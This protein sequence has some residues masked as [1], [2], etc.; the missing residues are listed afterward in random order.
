MGAGP[1]L[2]WFCVWQAESVVDPAESDV[3]AVAGLLERAAACAWR[4]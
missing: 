3:T 4:S 1:W 2:T